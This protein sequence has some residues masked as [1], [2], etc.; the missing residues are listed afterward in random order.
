[1]NFFD[2]EER[3]SKDKEMKMYFQEPI[4]VAID[5]FFSDKK[6]IEKFLAPFIP[7]DGYSPEK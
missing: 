7:N 2:S 3:T 5:S 1:V 4:D 6:N